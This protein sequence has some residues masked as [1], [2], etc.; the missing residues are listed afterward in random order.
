MTKKQWQDALS[1][2]TITLEAGGKEI[3]LTSSNKIVEFNDMP[4]YGFTMSQT[5]QTSWSSSSTSSSSSS[6]SWGHQ[7]GGNQ[8]FGRNQIV[9]HTG[10]G[11]GNWKISGGNLGNLGHFNMHQYRKK[12]H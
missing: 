5:S 6:K 2:E 12:R 3:T 10:G 11:L 7:F 9:S 8:N 1:G 4:F